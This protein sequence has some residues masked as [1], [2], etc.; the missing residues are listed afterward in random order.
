MP[1]PTLSF[2]SQTIVIF[3]AVV[4][5]LVLAGYCYRHSIP[6]LPARYRV[7]LASVRAVAL[8]IL[9]LLIAEP[10]L[11]LAFKEEQRPLVAVLADD[12]RSMIIED[13]GISRASRQRSILHSQGMQEIGDDAALLFGAFSNRLRTGS[14]SVA[15]SLLH[16]G[17]QTNLEATLA[18][19][20]RQTADRNLRAIVLLSDG[21]ITAGATPLL[22][23]EK[24]GVPVFAVGIGDTLERSDLIIRKVVT[25]SVTYAGNR[26][27]VHV[28]LRRAGYE[29]RRIEV[30]LSER[31][32][33]LDRQFV[34]LSGGQTEYLVPM[35]ITPSEEGTHQYAVEISRLPDEASIM[36]NRSTFYTKVLRSKMKVVLISGGPSADYAYVKRGLET[37]TNIRISYFTE[38]GDG[39]FDPGIPTTDQLNDA[40]CLVLIGFP[41]R[42][43][44]H[45]GLSAISQ[46]LQMGKGL[47]LIASRTLD[48]Q[49]LTPL[50]SYLPMAIE[51][52]G[53]DELITTILVPEHQRNNPLI[54]LQP[55]S[56]GVNAWLDLPPI[57]TRRT[58]GTLKSEAGILGVKRVQG[59]LA[60]EPIIVTRSTPQQKTILFLGYGIWRWKMMTAETPGHPGFLEQF[61]SQSIRW[62]TARMDDR[63]V[64]VEPVA[65]VF[66]GGDPVEFSGQVY[67]PTMIPIE[68]AEI[69]VH[70]T[71]NAQRYDVS[72]LPIGKG[73]Y[74]GMIDGLPPGD[75]R[76]TASAMVD[77]ISIGDDAGTF[78]VGG[79]E[80][81]FIETRMNKE[82]LQQIAFRSGGN[83]YD[84]TESES[85]A[86]DIRRMA[87]FE[88]RERRMT[89]RYHLWTKPWPYIL[90]VLVLSLEWTLRKRSG[91]I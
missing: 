46:T 34:M 59:V 41:T 35:S 37:D 27:P 36:N 10:I 55:G 31:G 2:S 79:A 60:G 52:F 66:V 73:Q 70:I 1:E 77:G 61:L 6:P 30:T 91:M 58:T 22:A 85:L 47:L 71:G 64:R 49:K 54:R 51:G 86:G 11:S 33:V 9:I 29:G 87:G 78:S 90:I 17:T 19:L 21:N 4:A 43:S 83:Y 38:R 44:R 50:D 67:D 25:N 14:A 15:D 82:L 72:L 48:A 26:L 20:E 3:V 62:L 18:D 68:S 57:F 42:A 32:R 39:S 53:S 45:D 8:V 56:G 40:D 13:G 80:A 88:P 81:E 65:D 23:V 89:F 84:G 28:T 75:Y 7:F 12:S 76:F 69:R 24:L 74:E 5:A 63:P 16:E